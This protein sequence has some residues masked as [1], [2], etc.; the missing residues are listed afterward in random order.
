MR[1]RAL[2]AANTTSSGGSDI[3]WP[4]YFNTTKISNK[5]YRMA[6]TPESIA[7]AKYFRENAVWD[8]QYNYDLYLESGMLFIDGVEVNG[9]SIESPDGVEFYVYCIWYPKK[10]YNFTMPLYYFNVGAV[11]TDLEVGELVILDDD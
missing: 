6:P 3:Q 1:R 2:L 5:K 10:N 4:I 8:G 11:L 7:F 9:F